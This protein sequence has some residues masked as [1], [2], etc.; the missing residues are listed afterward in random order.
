MLSALF[1][2]AHLLNFPS[3]DVP[4]VLPARAMKL[5]LV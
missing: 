4:A 2:M 5:N 3:S 1:L